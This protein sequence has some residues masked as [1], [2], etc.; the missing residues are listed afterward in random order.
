MHRRTLII[1]IGALAMLAALILPR[2]G[3][4]A[5]AAN[6]IRADYLKAEA[7]VLKPGSDSPVVDQFARDLRGIDL[8]GAPDD[9]ER[10]MSALIVAVEANAVDRRLAQRMQ[11]DIEAANNRVADRK[12]DLLRALDRWRGQPY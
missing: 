11:V 10:T 2:L 4:S 12:R 5:D 6:R 1:I 8:T 7:P 3:P 9:V